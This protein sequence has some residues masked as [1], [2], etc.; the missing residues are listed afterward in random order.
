MLFNS[1]IFIFV[2]FPFCMVGYFLLNHLKKYQFAMCFLLVMSLWFYGYF[3]VYYLFIILS[4]IIINFG[5]YIGFQKIEKK[6]CKNRNF[7]RKILLSLGIL[8]N[9][10]LIFYF[11]Y[12]DFFVENIN[13]FFHTNFIL[14]NIVLPLGISFFTFQQLSFLIDSY[15]KEVPKLNF[16]NY[17]AFVTYFPQLIAGP[18]VTH[19]ELLPQ[20][21]DKKRKKFH[22]EN[23]SKG[24]Y[25]FTLG[26]S[27]KV[28]I[29][30]IFGNAANVG[31][32]A[33]SKLNTTTAIIVMLSFTIQIYFDFSGYCDMAI[34]LGKM[35]NIDLPKNFDS[36]Y[37]SF[38]IL[39]FW[40]RWHL[41]LTRFF[42]KYIYIPLGGSRRG[43]IRTYFN[44]L[45]VFLISGI[46]HGANWTFII[47]GFLHG[48]F[49]VIT[50]HFK[51]WFETMHS[52]LSWIITFAFV[53]LTWVIFR[54]NNL[55]DAII[56][57]RKLFSLS[58]ASIGKDIIDCFNLTEFTTILNKI[59]PMIL[60]TFPRV[61]ILFYFI[62]VLFLLLNSKNSYEKMQ[63]FKLNFKNF[64]VVAFLLLWSILSFTNLST[65]LYFNF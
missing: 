39:E 62:V 46:W 21:K 58:F 1:Y 17:A 28:L 37:K 50:R 59:N 8:F 42:T 65:F 5:I 23:F 55:K 64:L 29:A 47:W 18:I 61:L 54:A 53:N 60:Q 36:P 34:G 11:K 20:F 2:F 30:D 35:M 25:I 57:F 41:T 24:I 40:K 22:W 3:N 27:K 6:N 19:D 13:S 48:L 56:F 52:A 16:I 45:I 4:S 38:T 31:F 32:N 9:I 12:Y 15:R 33:V 14:K 26:L 49:S 44:V 43:K 51:K 7:K 10:G 63:N